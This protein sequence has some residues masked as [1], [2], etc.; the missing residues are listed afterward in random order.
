M[1][2]YAGEDRNFATTRWSLVLISADLDTDDHRIQQAL[3]ELCKIYWRPIFSFV[4]R[5]G[6]SLQDAQDLTQD[7]FVMIL[8]RKWLENADPARG[9][10]RSLLM[11]SLNN[12][13]N[14]AK[15]KRQARKRGGAVAFL[16]WDEWLAEGSSEPYAATKVMESWSAERVFDVRWATTVVEQS[17][18]R[19]REECESE[20]RLRVY[21]I[22][23]P[24]L[25]AERDDVS[26]VDLS[27][28][29]Q[30]T[31]ARVKRLVHRMRQRYRTILREEVAGTV[32][33]SAEID[34]EIRY[35][36]EVIGK[37]GGAMTW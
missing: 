27:S 34:N 17:L 8:E 36:C 25:G 31:D 15:E 23:R 18:H 3:S 9:R 16:S 6:Y 37:S 19:L 29:L 28:Q 22:L 21:E 7:F 32:I 4:S 13:L 11:K 2:E 35:L 5:R 20:G 33:N 30:V 1:T 12:F 24:C 14:D 10:F 26:Y